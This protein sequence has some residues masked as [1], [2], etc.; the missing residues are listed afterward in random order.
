MAKTAHTPRQGE[1]KAGDYAISRGGFLCRLVKDP[2]EGL[3]I[4]LVANYEHGAGI[5]CGGYSFGGTAAELSPL[6]TAEHFILSRAYEAMRLRDEAKAEVAKQDEIFKTH[7]CALKAHK[8][9]ERA[10]AIAKAEAST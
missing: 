4:E 9:A 7:A 8:D 3:S 10:A 6:V 1:W 5:T 2:S